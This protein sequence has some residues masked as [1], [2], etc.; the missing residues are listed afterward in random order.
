MPVETEQDRRYSMAQG[1]ATT[2][3]EGHVPSLEFLAD[4]ERFAR[5]EITHEDI[6]ARSLARA[7]AADRAATAPAQ[8]AGCRVS[9]PT[10]TST[11]ERMF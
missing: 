10:P 7:I 8:G 2:R 5:G 6:R 1:L 9:L 11:P 4:C 3:I